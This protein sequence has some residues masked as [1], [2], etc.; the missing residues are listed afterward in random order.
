MTVGSQ[1]LW[2]GREEEA[3]EHWRRT[4]HLAPVQTYRNMADYYLLKGDVKKA[5]EMHARTHAPIHPWVLY[6]GGFI[7]AIAG[8]K[9]KALGAIKKIEERKM[10]PISY[11][12]V[13]YV[14]YALGDMDSYFEN[15][16]RAMEGHAL[17]TGDM[18]YSP[19][20]AKART[21]PRYL[22]LVGKVRRQA[23]LA[24]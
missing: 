3:L 16:N 23:G 6:M 14:Y 15:L 2:A 13:A 11:N 7:D 5:R 20:L 12:Q 19:L 1:Y 24:K 8:D 17:A 21:D 18:M 9:E 10:G 4:E 22:E